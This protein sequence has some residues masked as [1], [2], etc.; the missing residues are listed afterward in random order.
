MPTPQHRPT[1]QKPKNTYTTLSP[2]LAFQLAGPHTWVAAVTPI[3]LA[4]TYTGITYSG[5]INFFLAL[6]LL[7]I[8]VA[9]Q[10]A[11][12]VLNDYFDFKKGTDSLENS[13][14]DAFDAVLVYHNINPKTV[15][16]YAI[17]LLV[18]A[19][20]LGIYLVIITGWP[21]LVIGLLGALAVVLYSAGRTPISYLPIGEF[22]SGI[23]MGGLITL[24]SC[25]VLSGI[26]DLRVLLISL[27][28]IVGIGMILFTNNTCDIEKDI[29]AH[30]KTLSVVLGRQ[31][32]MRTYRATIV[33]WLLIIIVIVGIF[34]AP[35]MPFILLLVLA[36]FP[37]LRAILANPLNQKSRDGAMAQ[38]ITLNILFIAFYCI[39]LLAS[40]CIIWI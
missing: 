15:L 9:M 16:I 37:T 11:V 30:R 35:G 5:N 7:I 1:I 4:Y 21:L 34:Y 6:I 13:S 10:S 12:N 2:S 36:A 28:C 20:A 31:T 25:Y 8:S 14:E 19:G 23:V 24:A 32:A 38:I 40:T 22:V 39:A 26:L 27:P 18:V 29:L 17:A 3:L 33:F